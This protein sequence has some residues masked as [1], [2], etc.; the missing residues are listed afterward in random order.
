[1]E[2]PSSDAERCDDEQPAQVRAP[3]RFLVA[4]DELGNLERSHQPIRQRVRVACRGRGRRHVDASMLL[5]LL[6]VF[7]MVILRPLVVAVNAGDE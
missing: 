7:L 3:D 5:L 2:P 4:A 6:R 1:M